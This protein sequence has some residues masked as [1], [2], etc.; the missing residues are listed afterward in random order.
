MLYLYAIQ[1]RHSPPESYL[2]AFQAATR[3][4][5][6]I[7]SIATPG[8]LAQRYG[9]VLQEL[10]LELL[11]HNS[12][13]LS[14]TTGQRDEASGR[15]Q[16]VLGQDEAILGQF[17]ADLLALEAADNLGFGGDAN[18]HL[19]MGEDGMGFQDA[20]PGSSIAQMTGWGQFDS[21]VSC[22]TA[23]NLNI[24]LIGSGNGR[25]GEDGC[26]PRRR[27]LGWVESAP[28]RRDARP[29]ASRLVEQ[30]PM[31]KTVTVTQIRL[32]GS[33]TYTITCRQ[34]KSRDRLQRRK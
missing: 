26:F 13:L 8:S 19:P 34:R 29:V 21:L 23:Q 11:R 12:H 31:R 2:P 28:R 18:N 30:F 3:C 32:Q 27:E 25:Y 9:V 14:M 15:Q 24:L 4:Q 20:S 7:T 16:S 22:Y 33:S 17:N 5:A 1:R 10:R 6:Q